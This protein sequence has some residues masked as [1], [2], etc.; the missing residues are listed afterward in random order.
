M[1][2]IEAHFEWYNP[3]QLIRNNCVQ[4][5]VFGPGSGSD[6]SDTKKYESEGETK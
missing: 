3:N 4:K 2:I 6:P 5:K 1:F